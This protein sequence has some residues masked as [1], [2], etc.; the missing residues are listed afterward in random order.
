[1][2]SAQAALPVARSR[3]GLA[4]AVAVLGI[5]GNTVAW[6]VLPA[7]GYLI[8]VPL[9]VAAIVLGRRS[10]P[11]ASRGGRRTALAAIALGAVE[12]LFTATWTVA[13]ALS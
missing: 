11:G 13:S 9:S 1:M 7:G 12:L 4:L 8:G 5:F 3:P 2:S 6:D 10:L